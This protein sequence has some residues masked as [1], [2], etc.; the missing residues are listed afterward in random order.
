MK[1]I[2]LAAMLASLLATGAALAPG[3]LGAQPQYITC[4]KAVKNPETH[5]YTGGYD[6]KACT[7]ID[8]AGEGRY[9][10]GAVPFPY[11]YETSGKGITL[12]YH[13]AG[14]QLRWKVAC[15]H[16]GERSVLL[17][18]SEGALTLALE[19]CKRFDLAG[20]AK[21]AECPDLAA[22]LET[23]LVQSAPAREAGIV[24][25]PGFAKSYEC[26]GV[27]IVGATGSLLGAVGST[28]KGP[29]ARFQV[30]ATSGEQ[31]LT[32]Y[33]YEGGEYPALLRSGVLR[34]G[35]EA[36]V[37]LAPKQIAIGG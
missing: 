4:Q 12:Y 3:A 6:D 28:G 27:A 23:A 29:L 33:F 17:G 35:V 26:G 18:P 32:D 9:A 25:Y 21:P 2:A 19:E 13:T 10:G 24:L 36:S 5:R 30:S 20:T 1:P 31:A 22:T 15:K 8:P 16:T 37:T 14:G 7:Q 11:V 34:V